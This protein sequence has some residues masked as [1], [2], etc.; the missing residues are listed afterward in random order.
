MVKY[1]YQVIHY[2]SYKGDYA[3]S[4]TWAKIAG[5]ISLLL[6]YR[7]HRKISLACYGT[8]IKRMFNGSTV[9]CARRKDRM[10]GP[11]KF[12]LRPSTTLPCWSHTMTFLCCLQSH[13]GRVC[14]HFLHF[15]MICCFQSNLAAFNHV[16]TVPLWIVCIKSL[17]FC[18]Y[19]VVSVCARDRQQI[20]SV[21][22]GWS[23]KKT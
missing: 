8:C 21:G 10:G 23:D 15:Y 20:Q 5:D 1:L 19:I 17:F 4:T 22:W 3:L 12:R 6:F 9:W 11:N 14:W 2:K 13:I 16:K 7:K 18:V